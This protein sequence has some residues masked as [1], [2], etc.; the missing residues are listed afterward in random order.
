MVASLVPRLSAGSPLF[1]FF[2]RARGEPGNEAKWLAS[3]CS[4]VVGMEDGEGSDYSGM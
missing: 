1:F 2:V 4:S 3:G